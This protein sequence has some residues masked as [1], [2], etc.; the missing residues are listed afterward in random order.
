LGAAKEVAQV[1]SAFGR[2][3]SASLVA[4]T[5]GRSEDE[6]E[7][8]LDQL[9]SI[10]V[11]FQSSRAPRRYTFKHALLQEAAYESMLRSRRREV[12]NRIAENLLRAHPAMAETEPEVLATHLARAGDATRAADFWRRAGRLAQNNSAYREAIVAFTNALSLMSEREKGFVEVNRAIASAFFAVGDYELTRQHLEEAA[13][14]AESGDDQVLSA[15][16]AMQQ[17]HVLN[18]YGGDLG[19]AVRF[20]SRALEIATRLDDEAL[21]YGARFAQGRRAGSAETTSPRSNSS[22]RTC[23]RTCATWR[24]CEILEPLAPC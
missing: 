15:E 11:I 13:A 9:R 16:I 5:L 20:G 22:P 1:A 21:A 18:M 6:L 3:F 12:H 14:A 17:S 19:D 24:A 7:S 10:D 2:E 8:E 4:A 23:Q